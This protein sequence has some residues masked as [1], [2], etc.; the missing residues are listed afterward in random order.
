MAETLDHGRKPLTTKETEEHLKTL[1]RS[2]KVSH[3][4]IKGMKD[5]KEDL[6]TF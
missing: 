4:T 1:K 6:E 3:L 5:T 2:T